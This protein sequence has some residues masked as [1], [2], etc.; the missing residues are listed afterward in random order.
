VVG[1]KLYPAGA[2]T[3]SEAGLQRLQ[4]AYPVLE[5]MQREGLPLLVHG[6]S[7]D[8]EVDVFDREARFVDDTLAPLVERFPGLKVVL[9][10]VTTSEAVSFVA[11]SRTG[12]A[13]TITAHHLLFNRNAIFSGGLRPDFYCL[14]VLKRERHRR[15]LIEA[16][17]S[18]SPRFFLGTDSAQHGRHAKHSP[19]GCAGINT[20]HAALP[21]YAEAFERAGA[22]ERLEAF[23]SFHGAD[24]YSLPRNRE[25]IE[26]VKEPWQVPDSYPFG[27]DRLTPL[28]A[29]Q[30]L[31]WR[32]APPG[33]TAA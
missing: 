22:L 30:T 2:T 18:G 6:E 10:H 31:S 8:P 19:C 3:N 12:V 26:L 29:G 25:I 20:A 28:G 23:A 17:T 24:F 15:A 11:A 16:A 14:P 1:V 7:T 33:S 27:S 9:E 5:T 32:V 4:T 21:F 13:A